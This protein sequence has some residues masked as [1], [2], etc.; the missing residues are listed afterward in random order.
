MKVYVGI[1][2]NLGEREQYVRQAVEHLESLGTR[3]RLSSL[4]ETKPVG[5]PNQPDF[6]NAVV[7]MDTTLS[8][9]EL[10]ERLKFIEGEMGRQKREKWGPR[11]IDLDLLIYGERI[12]REDHLQIP[13]PRMHERRFVLEPLRELNPAWI[14][15]QLGLSVKDLLNGT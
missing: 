11:E 12:V 1:G 13:H 4:R 5:V 8:P 9:I 3:L 6:I 15:P 7:E 14:H 2:S 10:F